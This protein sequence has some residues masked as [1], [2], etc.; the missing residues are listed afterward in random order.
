M[1]PERPDADEDTD[2]SEGLDATLTVA[3]VSALLDECAVESDS[4]QR[5]T[6]RLAER[7]GAPLMR[8]PESVSTVLGA[9]LDAAYYHVT[10]GDDVGRRVALKPAHGA[11]NTTWPVEVAKAAA[12]YEQTWVEL[13][14]AVSDPAV[15]ARLRHLLFQ[16]KAGRAHEHAAAAADNYLEAAQEGW[17]ASDSL[18]WTYAA[19][20]LAIAVGDRARAHA[21]ALLVRA[22][23]ER[24]SQE[25]KPGVA[26]RGMQLLAEVEDLPFEFAELVEQ[27][28]PT[29]TGLVADRVL[30]AII[31]RARPADRPPLWRRRI[32]QAV[33]DAQASSDALVRTAKLTTALRLADRSG[34]SDLRREVA[35]ALQRSGR[36]PRQMLDMS[37]VTRW[38]PDELEGAADSIIGDLGLGPGLIRWA[39]CGP[40]TGDAAANRHMTEASLAESLLWVLLP[41]QVLDEN[42]LPRYTAPSE[43]E[44]FEMELV[45]NEARHLA[46]SQPLIATG[47]QR[48]GERYGLP[49]L[50]SMYGYLR[51]W[52]GLDDNTA[53]LGASALLRFWVRDFDG[54]FY[55]A[56]PLI[57]RTFRHLVI[58]ADE[59]VYQL[60]KN[61]RPG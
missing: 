59:G 18:T 48:L 3:E 38:F 58:A 31:A 19:L 16:R 34:L 26:G 27:L 23:I 2:A 6:L 40:F 4:W 42:H 57:E 21:A 51:T 8:E 36:Q 56:T 41:R 9:A 11:A 44:R 49:N 54:S 1:D 5:M 60:Q 15:R 29:L 24:A 55:I 43:D 50:A 52:P 10:F 28:L 39:K 35:A 53:Y 17:T 33:A 25:E 30:A 46:M 22:V 47:L 13:S 7:T 12:E 45:D 37:M 32:E 61:Q 20:R 14:S